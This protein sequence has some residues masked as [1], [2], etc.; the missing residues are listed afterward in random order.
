MRKKNVFTIL[1]LLLLFIFSTVIAQTTGKISGRVIDKDTG[2]PLIGTNIVVEGT[3]MGGATDSNGEYFI[4]NMRPGVYNVVASMIGYSR[5][6]ME[7]IRVS[8]NSTT[9]LNFELSQQVIEGEVIIVTATQLAIK[10]DQTS[11]IRNISS[12]DIET[13][14]AVVR[15]L[16]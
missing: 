15:F 14:V 16:I 8:V 4:I 3:Q 11:S 7:D 1:S 5:V 9:N 6:K 12:D 2:A 13:L 10:K